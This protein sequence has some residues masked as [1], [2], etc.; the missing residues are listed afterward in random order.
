MISR[1]K[2]LITKTKQ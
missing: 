2:K 1:Y